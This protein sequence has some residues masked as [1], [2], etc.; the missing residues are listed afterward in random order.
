MN[1]VDR[2]M[3]MVLLLQ[4]RRCV[5]AE[6][7]ATHFEIS[8]RT[9]YRDVSALGEAGVPVIAEAGVGYS[10]MQGYHLPPV[11]FTE[12]EAYALATGGL[13]VESLTDTI[14]RK[15]MESAL[16][17]IRAQ[18]PREKQDSLASLAHRIGFFQQTQI[19]ES[20]VS[21]PQIQ[22]A[23][24]NFQV[25]KIRY[26]AGRSG[27]LS[28]RELE[29]VGLI[30]YLDRWHLFAWCRLRE[31]YRDFRLDRIQQLD[32]LSETYTLKDIKKVDTLLTDWIENEAK[33]HV[34]VRFEPWAAD[35]AEREWSLGIK[36]KKMTDEGV[37]MTLATGDLRWLASSLLNY[38][39]GAEILDSPALKKLIVEKATEVA[40]HHS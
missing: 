8:V 26:L 20:E 35:K 2:L 21:I 11:M 19:P 28:E 15:H 34:R 18:L 25:I 5:T 13:L 24:V 31:D 32:I 1:R 7:I 6:E 30:H 33:I 40:Q 39:C 4:G 22:Q 17:K 38:G 16:M 10:L 3:A 14:M 27:A 37:E 12:E 29:P 9:V 36:D 23:L